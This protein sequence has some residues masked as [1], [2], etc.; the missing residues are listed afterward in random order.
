MAVT[1]NSTLYGIRG[2]GRLAA[3]SAADGSQRWE[4]AQTY[5]PTRIVRQN[6]RLFAFQESRGLAYI[7]DLGTS[8]DERLM[9][10]FRATLDANIAAPVLDDRWL[11]LAINQ[12]VYVVDQDDGLQYAAVMEST[13][14]FGVA[15]AAPRE[16]VVIDGYGIP[17]R[18]RV[19]ATAFQLVWT[20]RPHGLDVGI[21]ERPFIVAGTRLILG[22][23]EYTV[24]YNLSNGTIAWILASVPA[25]VFAVQGEN[26]YAAGQG[27]AVWKIRA[28]DGAILWQRQYIHNRTLQQGAYGLITVGD[29]LYFGGVLDTNP[30]GVVLLAIKGQDGSFT[31]H[32]R[33]VAL[34]WSGGVPITDGTRLYAFGGS[35]TG[36]YTAL[37]ATPQVTT[38][39]VETTPRPLRGPASGFGS[40]RVRVNLPVT[41]HVSLAPYRE[42]QGLGAPAI[43][44]ANWGVGLHDT[45]WTPSGAGGFT[46]AAQFGYM[47]IDV[48]EN[49]GAS[50]TQ[51]QLIPVNAFPDV[52]SHWARHDVEVMIYHQYVSGY[53][54]QTFKPDN[55]VTRAESSTIIAKT[56]GLTGPSP[57]FRTKFT[58]IQTHWARDAIMALE[59]RGVIG[60][61]AEPDGTFTFRP[62]LN[63]TRGQ[64]ARILVNAYAIA[65]APA[66]FETRFTDIAGH[67]AA[68]DIK[69]LEAAGYVQGFH[70]ADG[71]YT[72]R[73][74]QNL[75]RA[76]MCAI[77]VRIRNLSR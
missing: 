37:S 19:G 68:N 11:Y 64:E 43:L 27:A 50:Y 28:S 23:N 31:W 61:F 29:Q 59:E 26:V 14:P 73:P 57:S 47:L 20:G 44:R 63:M 15:L 17:A 35:H 9:I 40:G 34:T 65:S 10:G 66:G 24:A 25:R 38:Q 62:D 30:D 74:E 12:G 48:E 39:L 1:G 42:A 70:E 13:Q 21:M 18:Y 49:S 3:F 46:D 22:L 41:A 77:V 5:L 33:S 67:W 56:L 52:M 72:Y 71:T 36:A 32:S 6:N 75:T 2:D 76:E 4:C 69:A 8:A 58:D 45:S 54:D 55:L 51:A 60:G 16:V 53:P 7:D